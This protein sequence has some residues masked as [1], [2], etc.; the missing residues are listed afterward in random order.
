MSHEPRGRV[1]RVAGERVLRGL[2]R[3]RTAAVTKH[4][5]VSTLH[6]APATHATHAGESG[7]AVAEAAVAFPLL[8]MLAIALVQFALFT[9]AQHV[10]TAAVQDGARVAAY[11]DRTVRDGVTYAQSLLEAGLGPTAADV[12]LRGTD[13]GDVVTMEAQGRLRLIVPWVGDASVPLQARAVVSKE[14]FRPGGR[15]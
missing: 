13:S 6:T 12:T 14:R 2:V 1:G 15:G 7:Q 10:V 9:H 3:L 8:L 5:L 4:R 11:E